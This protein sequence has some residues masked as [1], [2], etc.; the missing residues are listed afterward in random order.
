M[1]TEEIFKRLVN[2]SPSIGGVFKTSRKRASEGLD[3]SD[4]GAYDKL[5]SGWHLRPNACS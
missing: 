4:R 1:S 5:A 3:T 2:T